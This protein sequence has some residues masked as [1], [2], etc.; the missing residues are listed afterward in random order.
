MLAEIHGIWGSL[1]LRAG[2]GVLSVTWAPHTQVH[3]WRPFLKKE[4]DTHFQT[5]A[6]HLLASAGVSEQFH[7]WFREL[8]K[9]G[10]F[11]LPWVTPGFS[12]LVLMVWKFAEQNSLWASR[13]ERIRWNTHSESLVQCRSAF[14][15]AQLLVCRS[16]W[17]LAGWRLLGPRTSPLLPQSTNE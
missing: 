2:K 9:W 4:K 11:S 13:R 12:L 6:R 7:G 15:R 14:K 16:A 17:E 10:S 3:T 1:R 8:E 5:Q